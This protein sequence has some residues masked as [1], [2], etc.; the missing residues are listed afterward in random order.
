MFL[1]CARW[2][3]FTTPS[4]TNRQSK[5]VSD[6]GKA[7]CTVHK[8][9]ARN[10]CKYLFLCEL[11]SIPFC[12]CAV[13]GR[14]DI[15]GA[16]EKKSA[17]NST[18]KISKTVS[19]LDSL[20]GGQAGT[21]AYAIVTWRFAR[22]SERL[23]IPIYAQGGLRIAARR[24]TLAARGGSRRSLRAAISRDRAQP[25]GPPCSRTVTMQQCGSQN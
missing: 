1:L 20:K 15:S 5:K 24:D 17:F 3:I 19:S 6:L 11:I 14:G 18:V 9:S 25:A 22:S 23:P 21:E 2:P 7:Q 12:S 10:Q 4:K 13:G 16:P 8:R